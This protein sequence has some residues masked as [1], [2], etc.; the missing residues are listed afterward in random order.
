MDSEVTTVEQQLPP[1]QFRASILAV[2]DE[3]A[4]LPQLDCPLKHHFAPGAYAREILLP[5]GSLVIGKIHKHAH[6]NVVSKGRVSVMTEF[7]RMDIEAPCTFVSQVGTKR[8]VYAHEDTVWTTVHVT[9]ETDLSKL[10]DEI[11]A[12]TY[13]DIPSLDVMTEALKLVNEATP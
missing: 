6:I 4:K 13:E 1:A 3:L 12:K 11:I 7:G 5:K 10:E 8:A 9:S 2:Q